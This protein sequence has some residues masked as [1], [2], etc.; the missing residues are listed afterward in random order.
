MQSVTVVK[1]DAQGVAFG[2]SPVLPGPA[3]RPAPIRALLAVATATCIGRGFGVKNGA[4]PKTGINGGCG[5]THTCA[6]VEL[7]QSL[8]SDAAPATHTS[9]CRSTTTSPPSGFSCDCRNSVHLGGW[10]GICDGSQSGCQPSGRGPPRSS[11][12]ESPYVSFCTFCKRWIVAPRPAQKPCGQRSDSLNPKAQTLNLNPK[13]AAASEP[14]V[15]AAQQRPGRPM[16]SRYDL[17]LQHIIPGVRRE[18]RISFHQEPRPALIN[19]HE[20]GAVVK[21]GA[22]GASLEGLSA[23]S[24]QEGLFK[25]FCPRLNRNDVLSWGFGPAGALSGPA[26]PPNRVPWGAVAACGRVLE[27]P[28]LWED[29]E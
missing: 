28:F 2:W 19:R 9:V 25:G 11:N 21:N 20:L 16:G 7:V 13:A 27:A 8:Q 1:V 24:R 10:E 3:D 26:G 5:H 12:S 15:G 23:I 22:N 4:P 29:G 18:A 6:C 14:N 17:I